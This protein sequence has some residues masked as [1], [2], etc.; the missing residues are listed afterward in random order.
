MGK[1]RKFSARWWAANLHLWLGLASGLVVFVVSVTGCIFVFQKEISDFVYREK[2]YVP[3]GQWRHTLPASTLLEIAR[4]EIGEGVTIRNFTIPTDPR[5]TWE[6]MAFEGGDK[7]AITFAG[8]VKYYQS[9]HLNPYTGEVAGRTNYLK[10]FFIIIKYLHWSLLLNTPYGQPIV[11]WSTFIFVVLLIT[12][13][14]LWWPKKWNKK[15]Q[16]QA[17]TVKWKAGFKRLNYDLHNVLGFYLFIPS[18][19]LAL[20]GMVW[21]FQW[22]KK[23]VYVVAARTTAAPAVLKTVSA[24]SLL[25]KQQPA[26][27]LSQTALDKALAEARLILPDAKRFNVLPAATDPSAVLKINGYGHAETYYNR[28]ELQFDQFSGK[29]LGKRMNI[30]KNAGEQLVE[31]N[32][33]IHIGAIAGLPGKILAFIASLICA[34]LPLTGFLIW[35]N[36]R[37]KHTV[38]HKQI[39][40]KHT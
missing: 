5:K 14:I 6:F 38:V 7:D 30:E 25:L 16:Q 1:N 8:S 37:R 34:S 9:V 32:Y 3:E 40:Q 35:W 27:V 18:L 28:D 2:L 19:I 31:A 29:L 36:K 39:I 33:D 24:D 15:Q 26:A 13:L 4:K 17:F 23:T 10:E 21:S 22:F 20:T 11:G 12:G